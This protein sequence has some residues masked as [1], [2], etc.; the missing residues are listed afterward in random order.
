MTLASAHQ[1]HAELGRMP[2]ECEIRWRVASRLQL[3]WRHL[4][5]A[6]AVTMADQLMDVVRIAASEITTIRETP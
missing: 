4:T 6:S 5:R 3:R 2:Q 1:L